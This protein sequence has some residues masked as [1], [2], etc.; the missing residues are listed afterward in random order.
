V[1]IL[2]ID[3]ATLDASVAAWDGRVIAE[4][5]VRVTTHSDELLALVDAVIAEAGWRDRDGKP[6][7]DAVAC[8]AGP[9]S[10]TGLRIGLA[11]AKGICLAL[12]VPLHMVSSLATLA[13]RAS[14]HVVALLDAHKGEVYIGVFSVG[15]DGVPVL[16][17]AE[18][19][20]PPSTVI[21]PH[22]A[23]VV[24]N[25]ARRYPELAGQHFLDDD[26]APHAG[27]LARLATTVPPA[28]LETAAPAYIRASEPEILRA[29]QIEKLRQS[30][31]RLDREGRFWHEGQVMTHHGLVAAL[32]R[33]L[34]RND[35]GRWVLRLD[36][37]RFVYL[38]V[39]D[40]P[41]FVRALRWQDGIAFGLL[42]DGSEERLD[43]A[44]LVVRGP[45][46]AY[47][48]V[49]GKFP[50]RFSSAAWATLGEHFVEQNGVI[51]LE[52]A[53]G[54][55]EVRVTPDDASRPI[56]SAE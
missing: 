12:G 9:G 46:R 15:E 21:I 23:V 52:A 19:V 45:E 38:D 54:P 34:N 24:G 48:T 18:A 4:R 3:T 33:W 8:G 10:F 22:D 32:W 13:A 44:T 6:V 14:G 35:D 2:A 17:Q 56:S 27:D 28:D 42:A 25:G 36:D 11:T 41:H 49:R 47:V 30:G 40:A 37:K 43:L 7:V 16:K 55:Y 39:D 51:R 31:V 20:L 29:Q 26:G 1:R 53:G 5:H 50:A